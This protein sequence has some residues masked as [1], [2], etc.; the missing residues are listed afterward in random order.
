MFVRWS[1]GMPAVALTTLALALML[2]APCLGQG[3]QPPY[4]GFS[5]QAVAFPYGA[6]LSDLS[7]V[8][9]AGHGWREGV[10]GEFQRKQFRFEGCGSCEGIIEDIFNAELVSDHL[11]PLLRQAGARVYVARQLDKNP[12][13]VEVDDGDEDYLETGPDGTNATWQDGT[14]PELG[15]R[16]SYRSHEASHGGWATWFLTVPEDGYYWVQARWAA[17]ANRC[18]AARY[19][20]VNGINVSQYYVNQQRDGSMW[21]PLGRFFFRAGTVAVALDAPD[22]S[23]CYII[24]DAVRIGGGIDPESERPWWQASALKWLGETSPAGLADYGDVTIRP[25]FANKVGADYYI[26]IHG[27]ANNNATIAGTSTYRYNCS[28]GT[29]HQPLDPATCD[30]PSGSAALQYAVHDAVVEDLREYWDPAWRNAGKL[31]A[32]FGEVR[33]LSNI[34][35]ILFE[36]AFFTNLTT[37][38]GKR[39]SDNQAMHD[40]RFRRIMARAIVRGLIQTAN[41]GAGMLPETPTHLTVRN[42]DGEL[43][44]S[45]RPVPG[46][47]G[48]RVYVAK[49]SRVFDEGTLTTETSLRVRGLD[50][51]SAGLIRVTALNAAGE[52]EASPAVA[53]SGTRPGHPAVL[54]VNGFD[55]QDAWVREDFNHGD[56]SYEHGQALVNSGFGFDGASDEAVIDGDVSL[57]GYDMVDWI[58]G[59]ESTDAETFDAAAQS[60]VSAYLDGGGCLVASGTEIAW[61]LG[62]KGTEEEVAFLASAFG[63]QYLADDAD[64]RLASGEAGGPFA[65]L[66]EFSFDGAGRYDP[67]Y[68]DVLTAVGGAVPVLRYSTG[69]V[70]AVAFER[71][72][73]R[74][75]LAGFPFESISNEQARTALMNL[76][77]DFC[78]LERIEDDPE[79]PQDSS[80]G[81]DNASNDG[82]I[83]DRPDEEDVFEPSDVGQEDSDPVPSD[84]P[85]ND[86]AKTDVNEPDH[87]KE[88]PASFADLDQISPSDVV[89]DTTPQPTSKSGGCSSGS[90]S[91][92]WTVLLMAMFA[93]LWIARRSRISR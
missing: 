35:G 83:A 54:V 82:W 52:S 15:W 56:Y 14:S 71:S 57:A 9:S 88:D 87:G 7:I 76:V 43:I 24:A 75:I 23:G 12:L 10:N 92:G 70:A 26:S 51:G 55:R 13:F 5:D 90:P 64:T 25:A 44:A 41:P 31:V 84:L 27:N 48:Y 77:A 86:L 29:E 33:V 40:P 89:T 73:G 11:V 65:T 3:F 72:V 78:Q 38:S 69:G 63:A 67:R 1:F 59:R 28:V 61:D 6:A 91:G 22:A 60:I 79:E 66:A 49:T 80:G 45:W 46:A 19:T 30:K 8:V 68:P 58:L 85:S 34:P 36:S 62:N 17:G 18:Q 37:G 42:I 2:T 53:A 93:S 39:M 47:L 4:S 21:V 20:V 74:S 16:Q 50:L 81:E 32:N